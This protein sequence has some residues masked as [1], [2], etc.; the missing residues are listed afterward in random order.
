MSR[1][2]SDALQAR[3]PVPFC[4][5]LFAAC[6]SRQVPAG[7]GDPAN[8]DTSRERFDSAYMIRKTSRRRLV[9]SVLAWLDPLGDSS[10]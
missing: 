5:A 2:A 9:A 3:D 4:C 7:L 8:L 1:I 10:K 6:K